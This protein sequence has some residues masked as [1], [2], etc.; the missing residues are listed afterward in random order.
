MWSPLLSCLLLAAPAFS[1]EAGPQEAGS[2]PPVEALQEPVLPVLVEQVPPAWPAHA[3]EAGLEAQVRLE[4]LVSE[5]GR[6]LDAQVMEPVGHGFD[7][8]ALQAVGDW[9]FEP[10]RDATGALAMARVELVVVFSLEDVAEVQLEGVV[11]A[12]GGAGG[13]VPWASL[14]LLGPDG[15]QRSAEADEDGAFS[16]VGL[17]PGTWSLTAAAPGFLAGE[18][19]VQVSEGSLTRVVLWLRPLEAEAGLAQAM[20]TIEVVDTRL[21]PEVTERRLSAQTVEIL[22]GAGG[23]IVRAVQSLPGVARTP[24]GAG[25]LLVRGTAPEDSRFYLGGVP[26]PLV[27]HFGGFSTVVDPALLEEVVFLPGGYGVAYGDGVGG[28]VDL[29]LRQDRPEQAEGRVSVDLFQAR[30]QARLPLRRGSLSLG[31]RQSHLHLVVNPFVNL[32][33]S[34]SL[35]IPR[36]ADAHLAAQHRTDAGATWEALALGSLDRFTLRVVDSSE[37]DGWALSEVATDFAKVRLGQ[38]QPLGQGWLLQSTLMGG[39]ERTSALYDA[40]EGEAFDDSLRG[41]LRVDLSRPVPEEGWVGWRLGGELGLGRDRFLYDLSALDSIYPDSREEG[42]A[43]WLRPALYLEQSQRGGRFTA[44]PGLR[45]QGSLLEGQGLEWAIDPRLSAALG[46]SER[47]ELRGSVG[48]V[49]QFPELREQVGTLGVSS[50]SPERAL[51]ATL[52]WDHAWSEA[53]RTELTAFH[54]QLGDLVVGHEDRVLFALSPPPQPPLDLGEYANDGT[55]RV[56]GLEGLVR[57]DSPRTTGW[58]ALTWSRSLRRERPGGPMVPFSYD[59]P[60]GAPA[61]AQPEPVAGL[62]GG[63]PGAPVLRKSPHPRGQP[64]AAPRRPVLAARLRRGEQRSPAHLVGRGPAGG[65][66]LAPAWL[67]SAGLPRPSERHQPHQRRAR[68]LVPRLLRGDRR[69]EPPPAA[70]LRPGGQPVSRLVS[71]VSPALCL[72]CTSQLSHP[73]LVT[74][75]R[76]VGVV[77]EPAQPAPGELL[78]LEVVVAN[79][80]GRDLELLV[81]SCTPIEGICAEVELLDEARWVAVPEVVDGVA[82][83]ERQLPDPAEDWAELVEEWPALT[84]ELLD[85]YLDG[86]AIP[87]FVLA[88]ERDLCPVIEQARQALAD[89]TPLHREDPLSVALGDP[90]S[91]LAELPFDGVSFASRAL[92]TRPVDDTTPN[93]NPVAEER[94]VLHGETGARVEAGGF[95]DVVFTVEDPDDSKITAYP[96]TTAGRFEVRY[97]STSDGEVAFW[98]A[99]PERAQDGL[100]W[101]V[102]TDKDGGFDVVRLPLTVE[103]P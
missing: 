74:D 9:V 87:L 57:L 89:D 91:W 83:I 45:L 71:L 31:A 77:A 19:E 15:A 5:Q 13:G 4:V 54:A 26:L 34:Y 42:E 95:L 62:A 51:Q 67:G 48:M 21:R 29:R 72:G 99:A 103:E 12:R 84:E 1:Q 44:T 40:G 43:R 96:L 66:D 63:H 18:A 35:R 101:V 80:K 28:V 46:L 69:G 41:D 7:E 81:W 94:F 58:L 16:V 76:V 6:V 36:Y 11:R 59:Q 52:G 39:P 27:F 20:E 92:P 2:Q 60:S 55:G 14:L 53:W 24:F 70:R 61:A 23:D 79:P 64:R 50:L 68:H 88:C 82:R 56:T 73:S 49:H 25:Q 33:P 65:Q 3:L 100:I 32:D 37:P 78:E 17:G 97:R 90:A 85:E 38:R 98:L 93:D 8:A 102:F 10:A 86:G 30:A 75:V 22:P 47:S